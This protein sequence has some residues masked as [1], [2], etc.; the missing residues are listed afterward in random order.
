MHTVNV[1]AWNNKLTDVYFILFW[2]EIIVTISLKARK[3][4]EASYEIKTN[5]SSMAKAEHTEQSATKLPR[6]IGFH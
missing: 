6:W 5:A 3:H 2:N 1:S 4:D